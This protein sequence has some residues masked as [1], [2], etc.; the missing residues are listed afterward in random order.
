MAHVICEPCINVKSAEC[1]KVCPV[2][3]I[4]PTPEE[5]EF[6]SEKLLYINPAEC[7]DCGACVSVCPVAAIFPDTDVPDKWKNYTEIN[8][9]FY[10]K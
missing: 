5:P 3:C 2:N 8:K 7:I 6:K 9:K 4:H 1:T 10:E